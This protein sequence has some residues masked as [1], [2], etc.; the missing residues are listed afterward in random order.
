MVCLQKGGNADGCPF[1]RNRRVDDWRGALKRHKLVDLS[2]SRSELAHGMR[3]AIKSNSF[4]KEH[5]VK[6]FRPAVS[7]NRTGWV[8]TNDPAQNATDVTQG[9][10]R[11]KL[12]QFC[13]ERK[14]GKRADYLRRELR[15]PS[16]R[17]AMA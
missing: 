15:S 2:W 5:T 10:I 4:T 8:S 13:G 3:K 1:K 9:A 6:L 12:E 14:H 17:M 7:I 11:W 16:I